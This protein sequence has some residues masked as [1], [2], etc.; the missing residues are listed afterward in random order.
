MLL[1]LRRLATLF[2]VVCLGLQSGCLGSVFTV[3]REGKAV[4]TS[5][6]KTHCVGRY[7]IDLPP[8]VEVKLKTTY[9]FFSSGAP[10]IAYLDGVKKD[11]L[12]QIV[13]QRVA[14][15]AKVTNRKT[16]SPMYVATKNLPNGGFAVVQWRSAASDAQLLVECYFVSK[17]QRQYVFKYMLNASPKYQENALKRCTAIAE[18]LYSREQNEIPT[19][20]GFCVPH[21]IVS[22]N[23]LKLVD[24]SM[25][26]YSQLIFFFPEYPNASFVFSTE[27]LMNTPRKLLDQLDVEY[28][29]WGHKD[30]KVI[31][32]GRRDAGPVYGE[33]L[34]VSGVGRSGVT[35][36]ACNWGSPGKEDDLAHPHLSL[37]LE[38][39]SDKSRQS[40]FPNQ[41]ELLGLWDAIIKSIRLRPGA[42]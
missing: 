31:R 39:N 37:N 33:E 34:C 4:D 40:S 16:K 6:W 22:I 20:Q 18:N 9:H 3:N 27:T 15:L 21:G 26:E 24:S 36:Y 42:I 11:E 28:I 5:S 32:K 38:T 8:W 13:E 17:G 23:Q 41:A 1:K 10:A 7:L 12:P 25:F 30:K 29:L 2:V 35:D 14:A 19:M